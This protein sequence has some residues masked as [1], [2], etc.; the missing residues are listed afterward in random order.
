MARWQT[1]ETEAPEIAEAGRALL[2]QHGPGL[3]YLATARADRGL[4]IHPFCPVVTGGG[5]FGLIGDSPKRRDLAG[6]GRFAIHAFSPQDRDDEFMLA[7]TA[8]RIEDP[9]L[10]AR[11]SEVYHA[12]GATSSGDEWTF[13]FDIDR[14]LLSLYNPRGVEPQWPP[15]YL[16]W[17]PKP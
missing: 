9:A 1:L 15:R 7:G 11:V 8:R 17:Q 3:A 10:I 6:D 2:Y 12:A 16:R 4:R 14:A 5:I 13:E